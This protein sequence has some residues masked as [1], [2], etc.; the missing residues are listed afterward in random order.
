MGD[1]WS[2]AV[3]KRHTKTLRDQV[4]RKYQGMT[5]HPGEL[6]KFVK[7][8]RNECRKAIDD[9]VDALIKGST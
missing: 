6:H 2:D 4:Y 8:W 7:H 5:Y 9:Q 3:S 1:T